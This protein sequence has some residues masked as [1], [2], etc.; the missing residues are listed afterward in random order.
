MFCLWCLIIGPGTYDAGGG[1]RPESRPSN[2]FKTKIS[3]FCPTAP[4]GTI[5]KP[6]TNIFNPGKLLDFKLYNI[7]TWN[8]LWLKE[9]ERNQIFD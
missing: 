5:F 3:R 7:R 8:L 2:N 9:L 1:S 6:P 4:G